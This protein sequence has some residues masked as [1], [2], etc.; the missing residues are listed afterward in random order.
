[1]GARVRLF[2]GRGFGCQRTGF[3][4]VLLARMGRVVR[5]SVP[6]I[7]TSKDWAGAVLVLFCKSCGGSGGAFGVRLGLYRQLLFLQRLDLELALL[8]R[9]LQCNLA[10]MQGGLPGSKHVFVVHA[11]SFDALHLPRVGRQ[12][13]VQRPVQLGHLLG[14][15]RG[16]VF[17]VS[18][19]GLGHRQQLRHLGQ[20]ALHLPARGFEL[21]QRLLPAV[22]GRVQAVVQHHHLL[23]VRFFGCHDA[24]QLA[25]Q[26]H[27]SQE[28]VRVVH[29]GGGVLQVLAAGRHL[30]QV[31]HVASLDGLQHQLLHLCF[32]RHALKHLEGVSLLWQVPPLVG[33]GGSG[34]SDGC[35]HGLFVACRGGALQPSAHG[36]HSFKPSLSTPS[37]RVS[38]NNK[39]RVHLRVLQRRLQP[40]VLHLLQKHNLLPDVEQPGPENAVVRQRRHQL[41][42]SGGTSSARHG[43][44]PLHKSVVP[45]ADAV[46]VPVQ[47]TEC[48]HADGVQLGL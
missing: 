9:V 25:L 46:A 24:R 48:Q 26:L 16:Q 42:H 15:V 40:L 30:A 5:Q 14:Q 22:L 36:A 19:A 47:A 43:P 29:R 10:K 31:M 27:H 34:V 28:G 21:R 44:V 7:L 4:V 6:I 41:L 1:M 45:H 17:C 32:Q 8:K 37:A 38:L 18:C 2:Q 12:V 11:L 20:F 33:Q 23:L 35:P 39:H 3:C 13:G